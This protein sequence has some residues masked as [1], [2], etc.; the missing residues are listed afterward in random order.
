ML[1]GA[2]ERRALVADG[3]VVLPAV[4]P[5]EQALAAL[6]AINASLGEDGIP[7]DELARMRAQTF[8]PDLVSAPP[9]LELFRGTAL[10][11]IAEAALGTGKVRAPTAA[12]IA[13]RFPSPRAPRKE[14]RPHIDGMPQAQ[15]GVA[16]GTIYHFTALAGVFLSDASEP[17]EGNFTVW[18]G[19][20]RALADHFA[21][22]G[23]DELLERFP[24]IA[25]PPP[26]QLT[27]RAGDAV[28]AHYLLAH[29][30]APNLGPH[31]R[32]AVFFR[33]FHEDHDPA[34]NAAMVDLW[35]EWE[36]LGIAGGG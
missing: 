4:V 20:H 8:C 19:T 31:I 35:H 3:Y 25:L 21:A 12:Q 2:E 26:R 27:V 14:P 11:E 36:G 32:Y 18:P 6:A 13:L 7:K 28:L 15:N 24:P 5:R 23:T 30:V 10:A 22:H 1:L 33:L 17:D 29:S 16:P 9:I 34:S